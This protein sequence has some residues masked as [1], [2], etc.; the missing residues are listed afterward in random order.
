MTFTIP[1]TIQGPAKNWFPGFVN[2]VLAVAHYICLALP[3]KFSQPGNHSFAV[4]CKDL[5]ALTRPTANRI[6]EA[7]SRNLV[8][9]F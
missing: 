1:P 6:Q 8:F 5:D 3:E 2:F 4:P 7:R 9:A